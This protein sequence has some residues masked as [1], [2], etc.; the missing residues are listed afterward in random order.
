MDVSS[1]HVTAAHTDNGNPKQLNDM[2]RH[3]RK[4]NHALIFSTKEKPMWSIGPLRNFKVWK[5]P[6]IQRFRCRMALANVVGASSTSEPSMIPRFLPFFH[7]RRPTSG[8]S[9]VIQGWKPPRS[10]MS[11]AW[12]NRPLP[13]IQYGWPGS[14]DRCSY[15]EPS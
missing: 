8:S 14:P 1:N 15:F 13:S 9:M 3:G 10:W 2:V 11:W 5:N 6:A 12:K 7:R 4:I